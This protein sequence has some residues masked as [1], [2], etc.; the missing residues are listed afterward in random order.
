MPLDLLQETIAAVLFDRLCRCR[1][2]CLSLRQTKA[3]SVSTDYFSRT[4]P[5]CPYYY[6]F[7]H[8]YLVSQALFFYF[9]STIYSMISWLCRFPFFPYCSPDALYFM[10]CTALYTSFE[11]IFNQDVEFTIT[12]TLTCI[13]HIVYVIANNVCYSIIISDHSCII[14]S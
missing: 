14:L 3:F 4:H 13:H 1:S 11:K 12:V 10:R 2:L 6:F 7:F 8:P 5:D 9:L